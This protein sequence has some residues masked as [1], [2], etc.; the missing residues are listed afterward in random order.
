MG[1]V[2]R[3]AEATA[4]AWTDRFNFGAAK[5]VDWPPEGS[6]LAEGSTYRGE[7]GNFKMRLAFI[8]TPSIQIEFIQPLEGGSVY[9][10]FL[11]QHGEG[12]HHIL[13]WVD[14]PNDVANKLQVPIALSG[15]S[16]LNPGALW[17]YLDT[18]A[19]LG[20]MIEVKTRT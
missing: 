11:E 18:Q 9:A 5:F 10:E 17:A 19:L 8:E 12:I 13:F 4:R 20:C 1:L 2:V 15:S 6:N 7:R 14:D 3:D 16:F